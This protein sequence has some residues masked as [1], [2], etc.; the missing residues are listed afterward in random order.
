[1]KD[2][3]KKLKPWHKAL[4]RDRIYGRHRD[5]L[6]KKY[7]CHVNTYL[8]VTTSPIFLEY[9]AELEHMAEQAVVNSKKRLIML[10]DKALDKVEEVLDFELKETPEGK[11]AGVNYKLQ[12]DIAMEVL[13]GGGVADKKVSLESADL[14]IVIGDKDD[15]KGKNKEDSS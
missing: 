5:V 4:A 11:M 1:M 6:L 9:E 8:R 12:S 14:T 13:K 10:G 2:P 15:S 3:L 7:K